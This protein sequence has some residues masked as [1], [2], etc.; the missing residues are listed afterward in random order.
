[1]NEEEL[2]TSLNSIKKSKRL[3]EYDAYMVKTNDMIG[4]AIQID[5]DIIINERFNKVFI[6]NYYFEIDDVF[7]KV[8]FLYTKEPRIS[9]K[10]GALCLNFLSLD[11]REMIKN[12]P[13]EWFCEW[14]D[15][16]GDSTRKKMIF[17]FVGEMSVLLKLQKDGKSPV[18]NSITKGTFDITTSDNV[19]EV[20][21]THCKSCNAITIHSQFQL[22]T[23]GI[24]KDLYIAFV[25]VE[26][27]NAGESIDSLANE[28]IENGF[29]KNELE[30]YL[31]TNGYYAGKNERYKK[32]IIHE[33]RLYKVDEKF[34]SITKDSFVDR[35]LPNN[36]IKFEYT[37]SLDGLDYLQL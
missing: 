25:K 16:L 14:R 34:P 20:K 10:Y 7:T 26:E 18:W 30:D 33:T 29:N 23:D 12:N 15:L 19:Y 1:M 27:N 2:I 13:I 24:N 4:V 37:L 8:I 31:N 6:E 22:D 32:F 35:K 21:T 28:L 9:E 17:D 11:N 5:K 36:V 3:D